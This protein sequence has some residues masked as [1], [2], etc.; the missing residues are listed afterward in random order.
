ML[1]TSADAKIFTH[2]NSVERGVLKIASNLGK[3]VERGKLEVYANSVTAYSQ[4]QLS[5]DSDIIDAFEGLV[6]KFS[7]CR[8]E[9]IACETQSCWCL[10]CNYFGAALTWWPTSETDKT[11]PSRRVRSNTVAISSW[12]WAG[13]KVSGIEYTRK[14]R[15]ETKPMLKFGLAR[16]HMSKHQKRRTFTLLSGDGHV[17]PCWGNR[18][19]GKG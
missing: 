11:A 9:G 8:P 10:P 14:I 1:R 2:Q 13:W 15:R 17:Q 16:R 19:G 5:F 4:R 12:T 18:E 3:E 6:N 7:E